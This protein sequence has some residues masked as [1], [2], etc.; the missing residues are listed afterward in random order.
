M[1]CANVCQLFQHSVAKT[2]IKCSHSDWLLGLNKK[3]GRY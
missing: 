3:L 2:I 1:A